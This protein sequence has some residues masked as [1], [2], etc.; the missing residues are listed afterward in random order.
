[1]N[2][3]TRQAVRALLLLSALA[4]S[5][6]AHSK[7]VKLDVHCGS[8]ASI[9]GQFS[10]GEWS[11]ATKV[12]ISGGAQFLAMRAGDD[13]L[14]AV[15]LS[16]GSY[17]YI[18]LYVRDST[19]RL[20]NLHASFQQG[21]RLLTPGWGDSSPAFE[22]NPQGWD[23]STAKRTSAADDAAIAEQISGLEG[24]EM[25]VPAALLG[26][27]PLTIRLEVRDFEGKAADWVYPVG[28]TRADGASWAKLRSPDPCR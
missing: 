21:Q 2:L 14:A 10:D 17:R 28:S 18:D 24:Y 13:L 4:T 7:A 26:R 9:D 23:A 25:R 1:M 22:W 11:R 12:P 27:A 3:M 6:T 15:R 8:A 20:L 16:P 5:A 19:G